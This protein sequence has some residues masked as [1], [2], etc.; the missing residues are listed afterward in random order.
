[1]L[2]EAFSDRMID[3]MFENVSL[4]IQENAVALQQDVSTGGGDALTDLGRLYD[5][6]PGEIAMFSRRARS[7]RA[8][9]LPLLRGEH[10][11]RAEVLRV[12]KVLLSK[13]QYARLRVR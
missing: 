5:L 1:M 2:I 10:L 13:D 6:G 8:I 9:I 4:H 12:T 3:K 11:T 7:R